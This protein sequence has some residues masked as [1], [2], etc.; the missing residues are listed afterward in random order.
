MCGGSL[1]TDS[2]LERLLLYLELVLDGGYPRALW[3]LFN[4]ID[5]LSNGGE[6][7]EY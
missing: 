4:T 7:D 3:V 6:T 1:L 5:V 2:C